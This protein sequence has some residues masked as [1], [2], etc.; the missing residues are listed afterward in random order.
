MY[1]VSCEVQT[2][3]I[4]VMEKKVDRLCG[5]VVRVSGYTSRGPGLD[6][7][8]YQTFWEVV[9]LKRGPFSLVSTTEELLERKSNASGLE[10]REYGHW[11]PLYSLRNTLYPQKLVLLRRQ[12]PGGLRPLILCF[13]Y[14]SRLSSRVNVMQQINTWKSATHRN[15]GIYQHNRKTE[16]VYG[17]STVPT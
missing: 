3:F 4:Y 11:D 8:L 2:E 7:R 9:G 6:S 17:C 10:K 5:L 15:K 13:F 16:H 1:S 12:A 14:D